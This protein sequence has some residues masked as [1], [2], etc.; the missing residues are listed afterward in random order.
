MTPK[1]KMMRKS[2]M[3]LY[4]KLIISN[5]VWL[6]NLTSV[7]VDSCYI[8]YKILGITVSKTYVTD[9]RY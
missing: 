3:W 4:R 7:Q 9:R 8:R 6:Q 5:W 2:D 1:S